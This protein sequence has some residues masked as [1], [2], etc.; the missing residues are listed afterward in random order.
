MLGLGRSGSGVNGLLHFSGRLQKGL[1]NN[2]AGDFTPIRA[3]VCAKLLKRLVT[4]FLWVI[5]V[6]PSTSQFSC[7]GFP[8][9]RRVTHKK[10]TLMTLENSPIKW[11][12]LPCEHMQPNALASVINRCHWSCLPVHFR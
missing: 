2:G 6:R 11:I 9:N 4:C 3:F 8:F 10:Y 1:P 7:P 12:R 5:F